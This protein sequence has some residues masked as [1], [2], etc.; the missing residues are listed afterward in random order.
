MPGLSVVHGVPSGLSGTAT[1]ALESV[2][3]FDEYEAEVASSTDRV[4]VGRTGYPSYP[5][6]RVETDHGEA[7]LEG[8]LYDVDDADAHLERVAELIAAGRTDRLA[9]W[10]RRR[11]GDF[12]IAVRRGEAVTVLND[13]FA[14]LPAYY[15]TVD[16]A[17]VLSRE[18]KYVREMA[19]RL[20]DP[21]EFDR[22]AAGQMLLFGYVL[23][24]RTFF[25]DVRAVPPGSLVRIEDGI[26]IESLYEHDFDGYGHADRSVEENARELAD[27][28]V[29]ACRNRDLPGSQNVLSL[30]GGL[31]SRTVAGAC[32]AGDVP[33]T[34]ETFET[35]SN[36]D[37]VRA[38]GE[39][40]DVLGL[41]WGTHPA[42]SSERLWEVLLETKQGMN[43][44][45]MGYILD[46]FER[47]REEYG[48]PT[49]VTGDGGDKLLV[50]MRPSPR[51]SDT[52]DLVDHVIRANSRLS[53]DEA[54][55]VAGVA[56][57]RLRD[58]VRRRVR[59]YPETSLDEKYVHFLVRER[60]INFL[61]QGEDRN[62]YFFWS[63]APFY[64]LPVF[65][66]AM[67]CPPDQKRY[68]RLHAALLAQFDPDLIG[69][70]YPNFGAPIST[71][72]Y[73]GKRFVYDLLERAPALRD[74]VV[75][76]VSGGSSDTHDVAA[77]IE[78]Q[79]GRLDG[80]PVDGTAVANVVRNHEA[81]S[82]TELDVLYTITSLAVDV[83]DEERS[84]EVAPV[85]RR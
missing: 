42:Q 36:A 64:S 66:Y 4:T 20:G 31:D 73:A 14:R 3:F 27:R 10:V 84:R 32:L 69:L 63:V 22:L 82:S 71:A 23:G 77:R 30:S 28:L 68:R 47:L 56:P 70:P 13:P 37:E 21:V 5:V 60:G 74:A 15:A 52:D 55:D 46:F 24:D 9:E 53:I 11:D 44:L 7:F 81:H 33:I 6:R 79:L 12:L 29:T 45:G 62:R 25:R 26:E 78:E 76:L 59:S 65:E 39:A 19:R 48:R 80:S 50:D 38:A 34:A 57:R 2:R 17:V 61:V 51:L 18:L 67:D 35:G 75:D 58:S 43:F 16:G 83:A 49:Y 40:A 1:D 72:E 41:D 85:G 8:Y 54:A